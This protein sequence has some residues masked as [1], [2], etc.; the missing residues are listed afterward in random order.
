MEGK[1]YPEVTLVVDDRPGK[2]IYVI[3]PEIKLKI[4]RILP[5]QNTP[6]IKILF[7]NMEIKKNA[8]KTGI[9]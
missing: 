2:D 9:I 3:M 4:Y 7:K 1:F 8:Y 5:K 6:K